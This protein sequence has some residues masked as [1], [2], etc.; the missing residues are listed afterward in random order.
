MT[1]AAYASV[2][3]QVLSIAATHN[4]SADR[5]NTSRMA[6]AITSLAGDDV[7]LDPIEQLLV[8]LKRK[9]ILTKSEILA[10]QAKYLKEKRNTNKKFTA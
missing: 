1:K 6:V 10:F 5:D 2:A 7:T 8:N 4:V 3:S 9:G